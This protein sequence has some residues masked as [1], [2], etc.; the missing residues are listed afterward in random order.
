MISIY[1][2]FEGMK[3]APDYILGQERWDKRYRTQERIN[4]KKRLGR[5]SAQ[6]K[7]ERLIRHSS[8]KPIS[9]KKKTKKKR[10]NKKK[11]ED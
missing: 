9:T 2:L 8:P 11:K 6:S 3:D 7:M 10:K 4:Y 5:R 1:A